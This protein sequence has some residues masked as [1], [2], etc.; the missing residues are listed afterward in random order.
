LPGPSPTDHARRSFVYRTLEEAGAAFVT[1]CGAAVAGRFGPGDEAAARTLGIADLS[2]LPRAGFKG[3]GAIAWLQGQGVSGIERD[4]MADAQ[5]DGCLA[6]RLAPTEVLLLGG[7]DG[8]AGLCASL[9]EAWSYEA[10]PATYPVLRSDASFW[11]AITGGHA[12]TM[13]AKMCGVDLRPAR[14]A[15]GAI[16]QTSL[17]RMS[18]II[19][20]HDL[21]DTLAYY[22]LGDSAAAAFMWSC[23]IDAM[24]EFGGQPIG[25]DALRALAGED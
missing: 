7:L 23:L 8:N 3:G 19:I 13:F 22:I 24:G 5:A 14:F 25:L 9:E 10:A 20:R 16:A 12:A 17:A 11:F 4:N 21:G 6:A 18:A 1:V 2:P 15:D